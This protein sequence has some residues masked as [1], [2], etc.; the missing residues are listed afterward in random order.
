MTVFTDT[1]IENMKRA[2]KKAARAQGIPHARALDA[3]AAKHGFG[4]WSQLAARAARRPRYVFPDDV[5]IGG[6]LFFEDQGKFKAAIVAALEW[7]DEHPGVKPGFTRI[8]NVVC[9][10]DEDTVAMTRHALAKAEVGQMLFQSDFVPFAM[11]VMTARERGWEEYIRLLREKDARQ[12]EF[13][14][15]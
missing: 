11:G 2:A 15:I 14:V 7:L 8:A 6:K 12:P 10:T 13:S 4:N 5:T 3:E 1:A 9:N